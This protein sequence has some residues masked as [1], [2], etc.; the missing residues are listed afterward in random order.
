MKTIENLFQRYIQYRKAEG[1]KPLLNSGL[2]SFYTYCKTNGICQQPLSQEIVNKWLSPRLETE[3]AISYQTRYY[4]FISF[5]RFA[6]EHG[7]TN[8]AEPSKP[9][10]AKSTYIPHIMT[11]EETKRFFEAC[12]QLSSIPFHS[13]SP[14]MQRRQRLVRI[15]VPVFYRLMYSTG[16]RP[17]EV[18]CLMRTDVN[19][20]T[21]EVHVHNTKG[22]AEHILVLHDSMLHLLKQ[23]DERMDM[24]MPNRI[25][26]FPDE[27]GNLYD[28]SWQNRMFQKCWHI[29]NDT[30]CVAYCFRHHYAVDNINKL[31]GEGIEANEKLV[32]LSKS[33]GHASFQETLHYYSLVPEFGKIIDDVNDDDVLPNISDYEI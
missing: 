21:G 20:Q 3:S 24:M 26:M 28:A 18:R 33:M 16:M 12:D 31:I 11:F 14:K 4:H 22:Y 8:I 15:E 29:A 9:K 17:P 30:K 23:Y 5:L 1:R 6:N 19:L 32:A 25:Y 2:D 13:K 10:P 27:D 7:Y